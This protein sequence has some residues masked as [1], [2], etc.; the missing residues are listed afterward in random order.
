MIGSSGAQVTALQSKLTD[1]H[2]YSGP[3]T[4]VFGPLTQA[5]V[6]AFQKGHGIEATGTVGPLT[7]AALNAS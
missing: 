4:G 3:I 6:K 2:I 7:R 5:A 1:L